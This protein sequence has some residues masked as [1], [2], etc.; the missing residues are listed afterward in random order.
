[1]GL[2]EIGVV[3]E[4]ADL[5]ELAFLVGDICFDPGQLATMSLTV[6][7][8][9]VLAGTV[10]DASGQPLEDVEVKTDSAS[11]WLGNLDVRQSTTDAAG[12]F[13]LKGIG[14]GAQEL[15]ATLDGW[16]DG[17]SGE[18][19]LEDGDQR[20]DL[21]I[22]MDHG[23]FIA[24]VVLFADGQPAV[25]AQVV[26]EALRSGGGWGGGRGGS[27]RR[28]EGEAKTDEEGRFRIAG[29]DEGIKALR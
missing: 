12:H 2:V 13:K 1:M 6:S 28:T 17:S 8:G 3:D 29:L 14:P 15:T 26:V 16:R 9:V 19:E 23:E 24:G 20:V 25:E 10:V 5:A 22:E 27:R 21:R 11:P 18:L 7:R 4:I